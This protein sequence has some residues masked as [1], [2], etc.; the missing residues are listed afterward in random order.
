V[1]TQSPRPS[2]EV[3]ISTAQRRVVIGQYRRAAYWPTCRHAK[4]FRISI[5][6]LGNANPASRLPPVEQATILLHLQLRASR[7]R[8]VFAVLLAPLCAGTVSEAV[9][10]VSCN[11]LAQN[12]LLLPSISPSTLDVTG[13]PCH[14]TRRPSLG[15]EFSALRGFG[16]PKLLSGQRATA[17]TSAR[18][19]T[20]PSWTCRPPLI[21]TATPLGRSRQT[22]ATS[23]LGLPSTSPAMRGRQRRPW[24]E[25]ARRTA[26]PNVSLGSTSRHDGDRHVRIH[27]ISLEVA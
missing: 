8:I 16:R 6:S 1:A 27:T 18:E 9:V 15:P 22:Q 23:R 26:Q 12:K 13:H 19:G 14:R 11:R 10:A 7:L 24:T 3:T 4:R 25:V 5:R 20:L 17:P 2:T 21:G